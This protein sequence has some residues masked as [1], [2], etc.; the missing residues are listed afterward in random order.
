ML[1]GII[2][3]LTAPTDQWIGC[4]KEPQMYF[5]VPHFIPDP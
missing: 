1:T 3:N 5:I 2:A 4:E